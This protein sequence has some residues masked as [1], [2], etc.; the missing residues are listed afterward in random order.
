MNLELRNVFIPIRAL[1]I[2]SIHRYLAIDMFQSHCEE[3]RQIHI[4]GR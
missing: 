2:F 3:Q 4:A 1:R